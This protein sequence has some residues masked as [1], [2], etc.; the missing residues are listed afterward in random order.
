MWRNDRISWWYYHIIVFLTWCNKSCVAHNHLPAKIHDTFCIELFSRIHSVINQTYDFP[1]RTS[2]P[3]AHLSVNWVKYVLSEKGIRWALTVSLVKIDR[4]LLIVWTPWWRWLSLLS[5]DF[6]PGTD[7][8]W[9]WRSE[10]IFEQFFHFSKWIDYA[11]VNVFWV[12]WNWKT[13]APQLCWL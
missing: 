4:T 10:W 2:V 7:F 13:D 8:R 12:L 6:C 9:Q 11:N 1:R 3:S 5:I